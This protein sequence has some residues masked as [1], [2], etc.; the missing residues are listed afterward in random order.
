MEKGLTCKRMMHGRSFS[1]LIFRLGFSMVLVQVIRNLVQ[2]PLRIIPSQAGIGD[3]LAVAVFPDFLAAGFNVALNHKALYQMFDIAGVAA[4]VEHF[5][6]YTNLFMVLLV[7]VG[8]V[9]VHDT[10]RILQSPL[11]IQVK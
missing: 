5:L 11:V 2:Q 9:C 1:G 4:A 8:V 6:G 10:G 7:R 3:G